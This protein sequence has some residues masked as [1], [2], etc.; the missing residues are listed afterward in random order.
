MNTLILKDDTYP[1]TTYV[2]VGGVGD[3]PRSHKQKIV[4]SNPVAVY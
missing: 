4:G 2:G 3:F 1:D